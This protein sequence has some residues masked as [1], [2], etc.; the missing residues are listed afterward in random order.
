MFCFVLL[1]LLAGAV[2]SD[3]QEFSVVSVTSSRLSSADRATD[4]DI[5]TNALTGFEAAPWYSAEL[6]DT[7]SAIRLT[8]VGY[9]GRFTASHTV[10]TVNNGVETECAKRVEEERRKSFIWTVVC[11]NAGNGF[12]ITAG[13]DPE[14]VLWIRASLS[15]YEVTVEV[16]A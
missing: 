14:A 11:E 9:T 12:K 6:G 4:G 13:P 16:Y 1:V 2:Q 7:F 10:Y 8:I 15:V 3:A 5:T